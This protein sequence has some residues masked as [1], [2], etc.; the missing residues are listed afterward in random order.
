M[1]VD[2]T[3]SGQRLEAHGFFTRGSR[4]N[5]HE[6]ASGTVAGVE[7]LYLVTSLHPRTKLSVNLQPLVEELR[8]LDELDKLYAQ[9]CEE[10]MAQDGGE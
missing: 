4:G 5:Y 3:I 7:E 6:P 2:I 10:Q 9:A 1:I 8:G